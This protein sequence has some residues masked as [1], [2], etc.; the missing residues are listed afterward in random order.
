M[1]SPSTFCRFQKVPAPPHLH[2]C[3]F[4]SPFFLPLLHHSPSAVSRDTHVYPPPICV[5]G[6]A[7]PHRHQGVLRFS[8][9]EEPPPA[10]LGAPQLP[11]RHRRRVRGDPTHTAPGGFTRLPFALSPAPCLLIRLRRHLSF[12]NT[13]EPVRAAHLTPSPTHASPPIITL[14]HL[15]SS[16]NH[17]PIISQSSS[18]HAAPSA[19]PRWR[20]TSGSSSRP[21]RPCKARHPCAVLR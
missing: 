20:R 2:A 7:G 1:F 8:A 18:S 19:P 5:A 4:P 15:K 14:N 16:L 11:R 6:R 3:C 17:H 13:A 21:S 12:P 9:E 10:G